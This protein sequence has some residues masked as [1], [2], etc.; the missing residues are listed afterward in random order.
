MARLAWT[1]V[2][3][4]ML[5]STPALAD[6]AQLIRQHDYAKP[7]FFRQQVQAGCGNFTLRDLGVS[8]TYGKHTVDV[9]YDPESRSV[10]ANVDGQQV[11]AWF[12]EDGRPTRAHVNGRAFDLP[13]A[14]DKAKLEGEV[15]AA[16]PAVFAALRSCGA[17]VAP[18]AKCLNVNQY[19]TVPGDKTCF[20]D[21]AGT[22][23]YW[24]SLI[25]TVDASYYTGGITDPISGMGEVGGDTGPVCREFQETCNNRCDYMGSIAQAICTGSMGYPLI[26]AACVSAA[27]F[28]WQGCRNQCSAA[29]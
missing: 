22:P 16:L 17:T 28:L 13:H 26:Y 20:P 19:D 12:G 8:G 5:A 14:T 7:G 23:E 1:L 10:N 27:T 3:P 21:D 18:A 24:E 11:R 29:C 15:R 25:I 2:L 4:A 9:Q 6:L